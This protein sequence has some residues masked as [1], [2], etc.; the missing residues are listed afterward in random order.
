M[1]PSD[2]RERMV[3]EQL[4]ARGITNPAVTWAFRSVPRAAFVPEALRMFAYDDRPL[5]IDEGQTISQPYIV[6]RTVEALALRG[7]ERVLDVGTGSGYAAAILSQ[8]AS[9]V[10]SIERLPQLAQEAA[11]VLARLGYRNVEVTLGD[12]SLGF[13]E[14]A[15]YD[16]IAVA[17]SGPDVPPALLEQLAVG[18]RL[19]MPVGGDEQVLVRVT[20][21]ASDNFRREVLDEVQFVPL[22]GAQGFPESEP[23]VQRPSPARA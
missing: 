13:P 1:S 7:S 22:I 11:R 12:G 20:R 21:L 4:E 14:H 5:P 18:G 9:R 2:A 17:A 16:A 10:F 3:Q 6:A 19:V 23:E 8:L 15:P